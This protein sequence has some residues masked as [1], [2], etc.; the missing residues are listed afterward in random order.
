METTLSRRWIFL[1]LLLAVVAATE[2]HTWLGQASGEQP[3]QKEKEK[4][5]GAEPPAASPDSRAQDRVAAHGAM[6]SLAKAFETRDAKVLAS[7]WTSEGEF[8]NDE[9]LKVRGREAIE[10]AFAE[11]FA[12]T[13]EFKAELTPRSLRFLSTDAAIDEGLVTVRRGTADVPSRASY[14]ALIVRE[15]GRWRIAQLEES[16]AGD[17]TIEDLGWLE[18]EWRS[19]IGEAAEIRTTYTWTPNHKFLNAKFTIKEKDRTLSGSQVIGVDPAT[20]SIHS[21]LFEADGGV[22]ESDWNRDGDHW[23]IEAVGTM[24]DGRTLVETNT[25]RRVSD[26]TFTWQSIDRSLGDESLPDLAPIRVTRVK[27]SR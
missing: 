23:F 17:P 2:C 24:A 13:P 8:S 10:K 6:T 3:A 15:G 27:P 12:K 16:D 1:M 22:G 7:Q 21:W 26:D 9:G 14:W 18:G 25:L 4:D 5:Q 11:L 19:A 20:G